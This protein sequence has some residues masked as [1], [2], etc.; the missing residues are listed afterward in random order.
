MLNG[1]AYPVDYPLAGFPLDKS[2][3]IRLIL[4]K[5]VLSSYSRDMKSTETKV[6]KSSAWPPFLDLLDTDTQA[7]WEG[8]YRFAMGLLQ[9]KPPPIVASMHSEERERFLQEF[10]NVMIRNNFARLRKYADTGHSFAA[11]LYRAVKNAAV[12]WFR[13]QQR[14]PDPESTGTVQ[15][16]QADP[17]D[18][19]R[20]TEM[21]STLDVTIKAMRR[22][23][24]YCQMLLEM[25][26]DEMTPIDILL[27]LGLPADQNK[28]IS[29][30]IRQCRRKLKQILGDDG[31]DISGELGT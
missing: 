7:A 22:L 8:F 2:W 30:D 14:D 12:D 21:I 23:G 17:V 18:S 5:A 4:G 9:T 25:A 15:T 16:D 10:L 29:D 28:K 31:V 27:L 13:Q 19:N 6:S 11:W 24:E 1:A 3:A 20:R 26:A